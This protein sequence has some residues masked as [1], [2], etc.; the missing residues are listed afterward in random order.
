MVGE[1]RLVQ[2]LLGE[3]PPNA[4]LGD[5]LHH[6]VREIE[7]LHPLLPQAG[8]EGVVLALGRLQVGNVV[9]EQ[10]LQVLGHQI[11]QLP[12]GPVEHH[13]PQPPDLRGVVQSRFQARFR[14]HSASLLFLP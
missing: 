9:E 13:L 14:R 4:V 11:F 6:Q 5:G 1:P 7:H 2:K 3:L 12:A 10:P 8:G